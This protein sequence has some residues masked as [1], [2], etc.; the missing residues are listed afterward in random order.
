ML[1][2]QHFLTA[3]LSCFTTHLVSLAVPY[4]PRHDIPDEEETASSL[5][6]SPASGSSPQTSPA[7]E[8]EATAAMCHHCFD[9][10]V[11]ALK[12]KKEKGRSGKTTTG[13]FSS[14]SGS[15]SSDP[16]SVLA[17]FG[18][19]DFVKHLPDQM[20]ECPLFVT[21]DKR[22]ASHNPLQRQKYS[23]ELRGCI[24]T[25]SPRPLVSSIGEYA[26]ISALRDRRFHPVALTEVPEL[27]V[28]VSLLV[29]YEPCDHCHDWHVGV[30]GIIIRWV[31]E[32]RGVEYSATYVNRS[33]VFFFAVFL[34]VCIFSSSLFFSLFT[35][36]CPRLLPSRVGTKRRQSGP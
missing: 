31:E 30:H 24:G 7:E 27:R 22:K 35:G 34:D 9:V 14:I 4:S 16:M 3:M 6:P 26:L 5:D 1:F 32:S 10:L 8:L 28:A 12:Q 11:K 13:Y 15:S 17:D 18:Q 2:L 33:S 19:P 23:F 21:W 29:K 20:V 36:I 25:L